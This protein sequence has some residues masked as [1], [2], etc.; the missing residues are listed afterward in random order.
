MLA[1]VDSKAFYAALEK[2]WVPL[3]ESKYPKKGIVVGEVVVHRQ[4]W[5]K[6]EKGI[7]ACTQ[8]HTHT[9]TYIYIYIYIISR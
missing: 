8:I 2:D 1:A 7:Y 6:M 5:S 9:H 3:M 4:R